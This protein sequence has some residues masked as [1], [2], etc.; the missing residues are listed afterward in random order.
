MKYFAVFSD[1]HANVPALMKVISDAQRIADGHSLYFLSLGDVV[2]YGPHP[3]DCMDWFEGN[4]RVAIKI[5]GNHDQEM[6]CDLSVSPKIGEE[7]WAVTLW[8]RKKLLP[9][10]RRAISR[11]C[12]REDIKNSIDELGRF[13]FFHGGLDGDAHENKSIRASNQT[14]IKEINEANRQFDHLGDRNALFG[15]TH[16]Q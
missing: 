15:H 7:H 6:D 1:I 5:C 13:V 12:K 10:H 3:N 16:F 4:R 11:W 8:T 2:D 14:Y 9:K